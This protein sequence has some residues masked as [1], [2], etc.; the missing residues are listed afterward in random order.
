MDIHTTPTKPRTSAKDLYEYYMALAKLH[1]KTG[2]TV[3]EMLG[4]PDCSDAQLR[5]CHRIFANITRYLMDNK[6]RTMDAIEKA[7]G[8]WQLKRHMVDKIMSTRLF[9]KD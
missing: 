8:D 1:R 7:P 3:L 6:Q 2:Q 9:P 5:D 4:H